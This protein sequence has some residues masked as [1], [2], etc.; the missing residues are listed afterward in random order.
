MLFFKRQ[1]PGC[2]MLALLVNSFKILLPCIAMYQ[3]SSS[4]PPSPFSVSSTVDI[5]SVGARAFCLCK[6]SKDRWQMGYRF[7]DKNNNQLD[8]IGNVQ[9]VELLNI[10]PNE[11]IPG[12]VGFSLLLPLL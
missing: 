11:S 5:V 1:Q 4:S 9:C 8:F 3:S 2:E 12:N 7:S 6:G 10:L